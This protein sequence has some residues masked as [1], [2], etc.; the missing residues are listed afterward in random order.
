MKNEAGTLQQGLTVSQVGLRSGS[1]DAMPLTRCQRGPNLGW[2]MGIH[3][4]GKTNRG[5]KIIPPRILKNP[6]P[7]FS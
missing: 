6:R 7:F 3:G 1:D 2:G 4:E 5:I